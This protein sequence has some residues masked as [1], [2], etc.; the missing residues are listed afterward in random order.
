M[1]SDNCGDFFEDIKFEVAY[2]EAERNLDV[3]QKAE[4]RM[5]ENLMHSCDI[6]M[7]L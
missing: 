1:E 6:V 4:L 7:S 5:K 2:E 3:A